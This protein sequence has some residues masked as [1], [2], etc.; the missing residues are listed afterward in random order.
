MTQS[1]KDRNTVRKAGDY[2]AYSVKGGTKIYA[3]T[4]VCLD[5][6]GY[7][8]PGSDT[9]GIKFAGVSRQYVDNSPGADGALKVEVWRTGCFEMT[10]SGIGMANVG[11][12]V[13]IVDDHTVNLASVTT[14][15]I[16]CGKIS[17]YVVATSVYVDIAR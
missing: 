16:P 14:N 10:T 4:I 12:A 9:A 13:C 6:N 3:G 17:E 11:S 15:D 2:A 7:A 5:A 8:I 1:T